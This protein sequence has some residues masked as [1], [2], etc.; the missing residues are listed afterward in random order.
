MVSDN[1]FHNERGSNGSQNYEATL[2]KNRQQNDNASAA[3]DQNKTN[4]IKT[5]YR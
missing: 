4:I 1:D 3:S 5:Q 2:V